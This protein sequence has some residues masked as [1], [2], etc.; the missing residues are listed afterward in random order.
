[1]ETGITIISTHVYI[2]IYFSV[3]L[4]LKLELK[5]PDW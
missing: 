3:H 5:F 4:F 1:M 2:P